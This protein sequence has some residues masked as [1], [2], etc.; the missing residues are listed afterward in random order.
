P[1]RIDLSWDLNAD[2]DDALVAWS[3][4]PL[5][6]TPAGTETVG[7]PIPGGGTVLYR[8][9]ATTVSH[10]GLASGTTYYYRAWSIPTGAAFSTGVYSATTAISLSVPFSEGFE[11]GGLI[12]AG[13]T[14]QQITDTADWIFLAGSIYGDPAGAHG[15]SYNANLVSFSASDHKTRLVTPLIDF[16]AAT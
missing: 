16:G 6:G 8:G 3:T 15:G 10:T 7:D 2:S 13:W 5:F 11:N 12:P 9:T 4:T 14:Q 1:S